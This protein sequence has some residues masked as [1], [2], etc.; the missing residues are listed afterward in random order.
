MVL[1]DLFNDIMG[2]IVPGWESRPD[3]MKKI[4]IKPDPN[5][6]VQAAVKV[7]PQTAPKI[8]GAAE[9][10][11]LNVYVQTPTGAVPVT[12]WTAELAAQGYGLYTRTKTAIGEI[13]GWV[14]LLGGGVLLIVLMPRGRR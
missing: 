8:I 13:P 12:P 1:G 11:G 5:K 4:Q 7:A 9:Q 3:W 2:A 14:W 10:A 6:L